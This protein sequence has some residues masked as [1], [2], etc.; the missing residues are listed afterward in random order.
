MKISPRRFALLAVALVGLGV[1]VA[2]ATAQTSN[3]QLTALDKA[4]VAHMANDYQYAPV[5]ETLLDPIYNVTY[6]WQGVLL[7]SNQRLTIQTSRAGRQYGTFK[8]S[9]VTGG[10]TT[11]AYATLP[12]YFSSDSAGYTPTTVIALGSTTAGGFE[13][14]VSLARFEAILNSNGYMSIDVRSTN[15]TDKYVN[16]KLPTGK[17][18]RSVAGTF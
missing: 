5:L 7:G 3:S 6:S 14:I 15:N 16:C 8:H 18:V 12:C 10:L 1:G 13:T 4:V 11:A 17:L 9:T 2:Y